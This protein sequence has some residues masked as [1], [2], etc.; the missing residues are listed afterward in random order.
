V[1]RLDSLQ[2]FAL[3]LLRAALGIIFI[4]HGYPKLFRSGTG[5]Q[6]FFIQHGLPGW[7]LY[8]SGVLE[9]FGG[10]MLILGL[11][12]RAAALLLAIEMV[13]MIWKV[14][15][16]GGY[17]AVREYEYPLVLATACLALA[18]IGAGMISVDHPLL[19]G[20]SRP[21]RSAKK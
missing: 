4:S 7:M 3:L 16:A 12:T 2:P 18:T 8:V 5:M 10:A 14:H 17:L 20:N 21:P 1:K 15:S 11:F 6:Q 19:G 9:L 13:V